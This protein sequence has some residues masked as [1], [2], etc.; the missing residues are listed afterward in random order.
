MTD[1]LKGIEESFYHSSDWPDGLV[2]FLEPEAVTWL[3]DEVKQLRAQVDRAME[4]IGVR[5]CPP[6]SLEKCRELR[7]DGINCNDDECTTKYILEG[8]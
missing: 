7:S 4:I 8:K 1:E 6:I 3:I 2:D 5:L